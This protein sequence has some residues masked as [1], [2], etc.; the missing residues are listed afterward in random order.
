MLFGTTYLVA[1]SG[2]LPQN[3]PLLLACL[4]VVPAA[5]VLLALA[6]PRPGRRLVLTALG[7]GAVQFGLF[8]ACFFLATDRL[9]NAVAAVV[10]NTGPLWVLA[11]SWLALGERPSGRRWA[12]GC[13]GLAGVALVVGAS[14]GDLRGSGVVFGLLAAL[15]LA[16]GLVATRRFLG[17]LRPLD[18]AALQLSSGAAVLVVLAALLERRET[19]VDAGLVL[20][21]AYLSLVLTTFPYVLLIRGVARLGAGRVALLSP[22][23]PAVAALLGW[24]VRGQGLS[25]LQC[26]GLGVVAAA[27]VGAQRR[28]P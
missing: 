25:A 8:F 22:I 17:A 23:T 7:V 15:A 1:T 19:H 26:L 18:S 11:L 27:L 21:A 16:L 5:L 12:A 6:R 13:A 14:P 20:S 24:L 28:D 2:L 10:T 3:R 4:R 9:P